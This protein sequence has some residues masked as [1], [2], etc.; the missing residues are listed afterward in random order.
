MNECL[1][2]LI[3]ED[4]DNDL[5]TDVTDEVKVNL[6]SGSPHGTTHD[7]TKQETTPTKL[8]I[9]KDTDDEGKDVI[10]NNIIINYYY[11]LL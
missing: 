7:I 9:D 2:L 5:S 8:N 4:D 3:I 10:I 11:Y 6:L 1:K